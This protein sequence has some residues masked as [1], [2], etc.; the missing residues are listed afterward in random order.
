MPRRPSGVTQRARVASRF[1]DA[2]DKPPTER[3]IWLV[4][5]AVFLFVKQSPPDR[6]LLAVTVILAIG[7]SIVV[8]RHPLGALCALAALLPWQLQIPALLYRLGVPADVLRPLAA[9]KETIVIG[10]LI[11]AYP[12]MKERG[13]DSIDR[14]VVGF[15]AIVFVY[16]AFPRVFSS[17]APTD[18]I[19]R[20]A[21]IR[22][23]AGFLLLFLGCRHLTVDDR[24]RRRAV[25]GVLIAGVVLASGAVVQK[26]S[27][28]WFADFNTKTLAVP[29]YAAEVRNVDT[30]NRSFNYLDS[31]RPGSFYGSGNALAGYLVVPFALGLGLLR[32][33]PRPWIGVATAA[34]AIG[35]VLSATRA[36]IIAM[37]ICV[38]VALWTRSRGD[39]RHRSRLTLL[40]LGGLAVLIPVAA[41]TGLASRF[42]EVTQEA[43]TS[44]QGA[45]RAGIERGVDLLV[46]KPLGLGLGTTTGTG[47]RFGSTST[48]NDNQYVIVGNEV[49]VVAAVVFSA[50]TIG[51]IV[52]L[53]RRRSTPSV[54]GPAAGLIGLSIVGLF[55]IIYEDI[56]LSWTLW[57]MVGI[58]LPRVAARV[59]RDVPAPA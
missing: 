39:P 15:L 8:S 4:P 2:L 34:A 19:T 6:P 13:L 29:T 57:I 28:Q 58:E 30:E 44:Q 41:S 47:A 50:I 59:G 24:T 33:S 18:L 51:T 21:G 31:T 55:S 49:G 48:V 9:W 14:L 26:V 20:V 40:I 11:A 42:S 27:T 37:A 10:V 25:A 35:A 1:Q 16:A 45:H 5:V 52:S 7:A 17:T 43:D 12:N 56:G 46:S 38:V 36:A 53:W 32:S 54:V 3:L 23:S 22:Q